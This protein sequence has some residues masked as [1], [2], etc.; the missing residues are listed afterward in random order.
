MAAILESERIIKLA[1]NVISRQSSSVQPTLDLR[2]IGAQ[3]RS[4]IQTTPKID[5]EE[6]KA[7]EKHLD[8]STKQDDA[9]LHKSEDK[10]TVLV[11]TTGKVKKKLGKAKSSDTTIESIDNNNKKHVPEKPQKRQVET[12]T[13]V[14]EPECQK[15]NYLK[16]KKAQNKKESKQIEVV[17][18]PYEEET[19][20][21][22]TESSNNEE[23]EKPVKLPL[24]K[25]NSR[26]DNQK[27]EE[28]EI[29][30][31]KVERRR[32]SQKH[33]HKKEMKENIQD[34][35]LD[36]SK[37]KPKPNKCQKER[38]EKQ[39]PNPKKIIDRTI[40]RPHSE[41]VMTNS[42]STRVSPSIPSTTIWGENRATFSDVVAR[43]E[44]GNTASRLPQTPS[45]KP[46]MYVEPYKQSNTELGPIGS[47]KENYWSGNVLPVNTSNDQFNQ[48][49]LSSSNSNIF[50]NSVNADNSNTFLDL[51][52]MRESSIL[53]F[54]QPN[55]YQQNTV[56]PPV[57]GK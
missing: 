13:Y 35:K 5:A 2:L 45:T 53:N 44:Q 38:K 42:T 10:Y 57:Q 34:N 33:N 15:K 19:S 37:D 11:P 21:T 51:N 22:T 52:T 6:P 27:Q 23:I 30:H 28:T 25:C 56:S 4:E 20:S 16:E 32:S 46:T 49:Q 50:E 9:K 43:S 55:A 17:Q 39:H 1:L 47:R 8:R 48:I 29:Q 7:K 31:P 36:V 40:S 3:T 14:T 41:T 24:K 18:V 26:N 54:M 12:K